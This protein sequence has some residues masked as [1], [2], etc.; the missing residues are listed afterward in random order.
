MESSTGAATIDKPWDHAW[1]TEEMRQNRRH[2]NLAADSGLLKHLQQFSENITKKVNETQEAL[3]SMTAQ[4]NETAILVD[5]ITNT[6]LAL[7]NTQFIESRVQEDNV[8]IDQPVEDLAK[9]GHDQELSANDLLVS[10]CKSIKEGLKIMDEK[11]EKVEVVASDSEDEDDN[12]IQ[13]VILRPKDP[14]QDRPLPYVF[15]TEQWEASSK[16]GLESS[17]SESEQNN[18]DE[19]SPSDTDD[20]NIGNI[21]SANS[22]IA[23]GIGRSPSLSSESNDYNIESSSIKDNDKNRLYAR[24]QDT[25]N[26]DAESTTPSSVLPKVNNGPPSFAEE[27]AKRLGSVL[28]SQ[29]NVIHESD[30]ES[31]NRSKDIFAQD[32]D[33][34]VFS[35]KSD[36]LFS[37]GKNLFSDEVPATSWKNKPIKIINKNIIPASIDVPPPLSKM[38]SVPKS[39]IDDLFG[40]VEDSEDSDDIFSKKASKNIYADEKEVLRSEI[41]NKQ[42]NFNVEAVQNVSA[43]TTSTP[44]TN[45]RMKGLFGDE[46]DDNLFSSASKQIKSSEEPLLRSVKKKPVGGVSIFGKVDILSS[47][48]FA[49][50]PSSSTSSSSAEESE[51]SEQRSNDPVNFTATTEP[52]TSKSNVSNSGTNAFSS[53]EAGN[54]G[55]STTMSNTGS[56]S[57]ISVRPPSSDNTASLGGSSLGADFQPLMSSSRLKSEEIYRE[58]VASDSLFAASKSSQQPLPRQDVSEEPEDVFGPPPLPKAGDNSKPKS[59]VASLFDD[60]DSDDDLFGSPSLKTSSAPTPSKPQQSQKKKGLFDDDDDDGDLFRGRDAPDV[61]L[62]DAASKKLKF[63]SLFDDE[64]PDDDGLFGDNKSK[65]KASSNVSCILGEKEQTESVDSFFHEEKSSDSVFSEVK[66]ESKKELEKSVFKDPAKVDKISEKKSSSKSLFDDTEDSNLFSAVP[67]LTPLVGAATVL[68]KTS[69]RNNASG[70]FDDTEDS[71]LF[72]SSSSSKNVHEKNI[73]EKSIDSLCSDS[74]DPKGFGA[75]DSK[76]IEQTSSKSDSLVDDK[77][78]VSKPD[79]LFEDK[80]KTSKSLFE[81]EELKSDSLFKEKPKA[82]NLLFEGGKSKIDSLFEDTSKVSQAKKLTTSI[83]DDSDDDDDDDLFSSSKKKNQ[84]SSSFFEEDKNINVTKAMDDEKKVEIE[85]AVEKE[86]EEK[87]K[88][89]RKVIKKDSPPSSKL[90]KKVVEKKIIF[91]VD[92]DDDDDLFGDKKKKSVTQ[93]KS[94]EKDD[95]EKK[96]EKDNDTKTKTEVP[97]KPDLASKKA[98]FAEIQKKLEKHNLL[99]P[100]RVAKLTRPDKPAKPESTVVD[101]AVSSKKEPPKTLKLDDPPESGSPTEDLSTNQQ[102]MKKPAISGKIK[103]LQGKMGPLKLLSPTD[104]PPTWRKSTE[105]KNSNEDEQEHTPELPSSDASTP[106]MPSEASSPHTSGTNSRARDSPSTRSDNTEV[107]ISFDEPAQ[108]E[109]LSSTASKSRPRIPGKRRPQSRQARHSALRQ[110]GIDFDFVDASL[111]TAQSNGDASD[112]QIISDRLQ[113]HR[114][115]HSTGDS[116]HA[117]DKSEISASRNTTTNLLSPSTDEEDL[118]DV[119][120]DLPEDPAAKEE[121]FFGRAPILSPVEPI[122]K[123]NDKVPAEK[124]EKKE[125]K[126]NPKVEEK[127]EKKQVANPV[128]PLQDENHDPLKD[129]SQLFAFVTKTPSPEKSKG[130][131]FDEDDNSLFTSSA[132]ALETKEEKKYKPALDLFVDVDDAES[133][134]FSSSKTKLKAKSL[135]DTKTDLFDDKIAE[136]NGDNLFSYITK[137]TESVIKKNIPV[138]KTEVKSETAIISDEDDN[139]FSSSTKKNERKKVEDKSIEPKKVPPK[140][141]TIEDE[142]YGNLFGSSAKMTEGTKN[143]DISISVAVERKSEGKNI[144]TIVKGIFDNSSDEDLF[145]S[146]KKMIPKKKTSLFDED[147]DG[148]N[149]DDLFG[150]PKT[151]MKESKVANIEKP[152][153]KKAVTKDLKKTAEKIVE[154]PLSMLQDDQ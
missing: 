121:S 102:A 26:S 142:E 27:L 127:K 124:K 17:S 83:F 145:A 98:V 135:K 31:V 51:P 130:L 43:M 108:V 125:I 44:E 71:D 50:R 64:P 149:D 13:S 153:I 65:C 3:D 93:D 120:P 58:R 16:V 25:L 15:G 112:A 94:K 99:D 77:P 80:P 86:K 14:Y 29:R 95:V 40:D 109:T 101:G 97:K 36:N 41:I 21:L 79:F 141:K 6:S 39:T 151:S 74:T 133:D 152:V 113:P 10:V 100:E 28:P 60:S 128:D 91:D 146:S 87:L 114:P 76:S 49:R 37:E 33:Q 137:K 72:S 46:E 18:E 48:K 5:N 42:K 144:K 63:T 32:D 9:N 82:S 4:L 8:E 119:P 123:P 57:G 56:S 117:D 122:E 1:S 70:F 66:Q 73:V 47:S 118:F 2:W 12:G 30:E 131:L 143:K 126:E 107:A 35:S 69:A 111:T 7:A 89:P 62:F 78:Q 20:K 75:K 90:V 136:D 68:N 110:S 54:V 150:K 81:D 67:K 38:A 45:E 116:G 23:L 52:V 139:I 59:K 138:A 85:K 115:H 134:L 53:V 24:S 55:D 61:D 104:S 154:D 148:E 34:D 22:R 88:E 11:Y 147:D 132:K 92:D 106:T 96:K 103:D 129:P 140:L 19:E 105:E 84:S